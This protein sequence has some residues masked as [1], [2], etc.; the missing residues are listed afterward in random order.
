MENR[1]VGISMTIIVFSPHPD[2]ETLA[3]GGTIAGK[4]AAGERVYVV[5]MTDGR[6]SHTNMGIDENPSPSEV[7]AMRREECSK[8]TSILGVRGSD[9]TF[10]GFE[11]AR[12]YKAMAEAQRMVVQLLEELKPDE[13]FIP[14]KKEFHRDHVSTNLIVSRAVEKLVSKPAIYEYTVIS[15]HEP[16]V[17]EK[18]VFEVDISKNLEKKR[19]AIKVYK[20]QIEII[21]PKQKRPVVNSHLLLRFL[22]DKEVFLKIR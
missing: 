14:S 16:K 15:K 11:D 17:A 19:E 6:N 10:L 8:A 18:R 21:S 9:L 2:D 3:C 12:L 4:T 13:V 20:S 7:I 1:N 5:V 22:G